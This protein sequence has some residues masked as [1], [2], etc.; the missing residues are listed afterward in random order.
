[1]GCWNG[2]DLIT[3]LP[4]MFGDKVVLIPL[5]RE[6]R[7][8]PQHCI[9]YSTDLY[10]PYPI[11]LK[12]EY[13]DY[14]LI[15]N[16]TG[17]IEQFKTL[18]DNK[19]DRESLKSHMMNHEEKIIPY[20]RAVEREDIEDI[21]FVMI[22]EDLY[23]SLLSFENEE[24]KDITKEINKFIKENSYVLFR[25]LAYDKTF[26]SYNKDSLFNILCLQSIMAGLRKLW[27]PSCGAGSQS[28]FY[29]SHKIVNNHMKKIV[30][31][32]FAAIDED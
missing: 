17:D 29:S 5:K 27:M 11:I 28:D 30:D 4:I 20:I 9:Y 26:I 24:M 6:K 14:G 8:L 2:T 21:L 22:Q 23:D 25:E 7:E 18:I 15:E 12:G 16:V 32:Y 13:N 10:K 31:N 19:I 3:Q 1:M